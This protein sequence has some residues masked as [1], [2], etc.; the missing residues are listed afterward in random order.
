MLEHDREV[1]RGGPGRKRGQGAKQQGPG[2][3]GADAGFRPVRKGM[4]THT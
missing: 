4:R 3:R 2:R 1:D